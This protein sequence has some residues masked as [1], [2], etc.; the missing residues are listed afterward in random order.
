ML[1]TVLAPLSSNAT[2]LCQRARRC[3]RIAFDAKFGGRGCSILFESYLGFASGGSDFLKG[4]WEELVRA[5][6]GYLELGMLE[7]AARAFEEIALEDRNKSAVLGVQVG[8][9]IAQKKWALAAVAAGRLVKLGPKDPAWWIAFAYSTRQ[10]ESIEKGEAI[11][12][13]ARD[14]HPDHPDI[15]FNLAC[16]ASLLG[17]TE[18]A[19]LH[20]QRAIDLDTDIRRLALDEA[21]LRPLWDWIAGL[22]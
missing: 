6:S 1:S 8:L 13:Q 21:D 19:K 22:K 5:A 4:D 12:L 15:L 17:H 9:Y 16:Y 18:E 10:S 14:L 20:L 11:L 2:S 3:S 7:D